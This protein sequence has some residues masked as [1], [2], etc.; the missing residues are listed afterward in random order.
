MPLGF[1]NI[2]W[3]WKLHSCSLA[4]GRTLTQF[5]LWLYYSFNTR[6]LQQ[7]FRCAALF[8]NCGQTRERFK[9]KIPASERPT[10]DLP[11]NTSQIHRCNSETKSLLTNVPTLYYLLFFTILTAAAFH[12]SNLNVGIHLSAGRAAAPAGSP[13]FSRYFAVG[14]LNI[15]AEIDF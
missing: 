11:N 4:V 10:W 9:S 15:S 8:Y 6:K 2:L 3:M 1:R 14:L 13:R 5:S 7:S 12:G